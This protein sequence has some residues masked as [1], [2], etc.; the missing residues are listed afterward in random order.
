MDL[1]SGVEKAT[2]QQRSPKIDFREIFFRKSV[3]A[4]NIG[5]AKLIV[6]LDIP[7]VEPPKL[8]ER[9]LE[10][11]EAQQYRDRWAYRRLARRCVACVRFAALV[12]Q[13]ATD[14]IGLSASCPV[15]PR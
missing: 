10:G 15:Y 1:R 7:S 2:Q 9:G 4:I 13:S 11:V 6:D 12:P 8:P 14:R 3:H 5:G